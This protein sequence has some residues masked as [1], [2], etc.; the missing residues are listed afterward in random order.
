M[1][2][3]HVTFP[4]SEILKATRILA[5]E[6]RLPGFNRQPIQLTDRLSVRQS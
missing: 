1:P 6:I 4:M 3:P 2:D 5:R